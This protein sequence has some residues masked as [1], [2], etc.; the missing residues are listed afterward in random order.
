M[1]L[2]ITGG[3]GFLGSKITEFALARGYKVSCLSR[4]N[5]P[6][7][8]VLGAK[9]IM[10]DIS[11]TSSL[12]QVDFSVFDAVIHTAA[13]AGVWGDKKKIWN[14]NYEGTKNLYHQV[15]KAGIKYFVYTSTPSVVFGKEDIIRGDEKLPYPSKFYTDYAA[16]KAAAEK[17]LFAQE[18]DMQINALRPHLIWGPGDPHLIP[19]L[20]EKAK[21]GKLKQVGSGDNLVDVIF[22]DNAANAHL[23]LL[24]TMIDNKELKGQAYFIGQEKPVNLWD[25]INQILV[26][27]GINPEYGYVSF[28][29]SFMLGAVLELIFKLLGIVFPEPP[30][31]RFVALQ[32]AKN[33]YFSHEKAV[34]EFSYKVLVSTGEGLE[35]LKRLKDVI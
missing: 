11:N 16:S 27:Y 6:H 35:K 32:L 8:E 19:R 29:L 15:S 33:H 4:K 14:T 7:L 22:V 5:Y 25:F 20:V 13:I 9:S 12:E 18:T 21:Q 1:H 28:K 10:A 26:K 17:F 24:N 3:A 30:M 31:T 34:N 2:L 23:D